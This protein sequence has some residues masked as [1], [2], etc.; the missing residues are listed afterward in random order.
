MNYECWLGPDP[1]KQL[2]ENI[3]ND[4]GHWGPCGLGNMGATCYLNVLVQMICQNIILRDAIL[5]V[6]VRF[7]GPIELAEVVKSL[8]F[9]IGHILHGSARVYSLETFV[10][11]MGLDKSVQQDPHEFYKLFFDKIADFQSKLLQPG[12]RYHTTG[13]EATTVT[14]NVCHHESR[15]V[16]DFQDIEVSIEGGVK[17]IDE[18]VERYYQEEPMQGENKYFCCHCNMLCD[19]KR[20]TTLVEPPTVLTVHLSRNV[21]DRTTFQKKKLTVLYCNYFKQKCM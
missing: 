9:A 2:R 1:R 3:S 13:Q 21:Y 16:T 5:N 14:C 8:Q 11:L 10:E 17:T 19:A 18:C 15:K 20:S 6:D 7:D 4:D 12:I